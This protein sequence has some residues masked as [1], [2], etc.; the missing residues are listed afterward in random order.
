MYSSSNTTEEPIQKLI[1]GYWHSRSQ[2]KQL[3]RVHLNQWHKPFRWSLVTKFLW[4]SGNIRFSEYLNSF[5]LTLAHY[6]P[7]LKLRP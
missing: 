7:F 3:I 1:F 6:F 5:K 2:Y 4:V